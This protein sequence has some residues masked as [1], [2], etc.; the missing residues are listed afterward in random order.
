MYKTNQFF[1]C[2]ESKASFL[3]PIIFFLLIF[4]KHLFI[5]I[6]VSVIYLTEVYSNLNTMDQMERPCILILFLPIC[7]SETVIQVPKWKPR[8]PYLQPTSIR[9]HP[10]NPPLTNT[11]TTTTT[12]TTTLTHHSITTPTT[13]NFIANLEKTLYHPPLPPTHPI[14][15][16]PPQ[17]SIYTPLH[18]P[19]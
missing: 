2:M 7:S 18:T 6:F 1:T 16:S 5:Y 14:C 10:E 17:L 3:F 19:R 4:G 13:T 12:T 11:T 8:V 15:F 9:L